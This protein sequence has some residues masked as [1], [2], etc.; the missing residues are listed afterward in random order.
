MSEEVWTLPRG[1]SMVGMFRLVENG[2]LRFAEILTLTEETSPTQGLILRIRHFDQE[3]TPLLGE[4]LSGPAVFK[5]V[6]ATPNQLVF[7]QRFLQ[8]DGTFLTDPNH[9]IEFERRGEEG[10][11]VTVVEPGAS[12]EGTKTVF[13]FQRD[14]GP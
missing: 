12:T 9:R 10:M 4:D 8:P 6:T 11:R 14:D 3:L 1:G 7:H 5:A 13:S 2:E